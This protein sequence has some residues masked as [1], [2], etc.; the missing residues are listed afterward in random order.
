MIAAII[1]ATEAIKQA[2]PHSSTAAMFDALQVTLAAP[3]M[4][5]ATINV[6]IQDEA[7]QVAA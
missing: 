2:R 5:I 7:E 4:K 3:R 1:A 6:R